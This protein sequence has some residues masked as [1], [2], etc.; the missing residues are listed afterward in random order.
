MVP[1]R[2]IVK[3]WSGGMRQRTA[4]R[5]PVRNSAPGPTV[6]LIFAGCQG[7]WED[8]RTWT[9]PSTPVMVIWRV[10]RS[11]VGWV[12]VMAGRVW[13]TAGRAIARRIE[14]RMERVAL[15]GAY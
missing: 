12:D 13:A 2:S 3:V 14:W 9:M 4:L 8:W 7:S 5:G 6:M 15:M 10:A 1:R 11:V